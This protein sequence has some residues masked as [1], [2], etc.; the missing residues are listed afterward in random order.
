MLS[1]KVWLENIVDPLKEI[2]SAEFQEEG[3]VRGEIYDSCSFADTISRLFDDGCLDD[4]VNKHAKELGFSDEQI[5]KLDEIYT[6]LSHYTDKNGCYKDPLLIINDPEWLKIR[7]IAQD[8][9]R[10]L[11][12]EKYLDPSKQVLRDSLLY[13]VDNIAN[14][15]LQM[16]F[17]FQD[18][19]AEKNLITDLVE[20]FFGVAKA[21][22]IIANHKDYELTEDQCRAL[23]PFYQALLTYK[24]MKYKPGDLERI[25][26][27]HEWQQTQNLARKVLRT[28]N[29]KRE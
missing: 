25:V 7:V 21:A 13:A 4:F 9:L 14:L 28:F 5:Q 12:V 24:N 18:A 11:H 3:W 17:R 22:Q 23:E 10:A 15:D 29:F 19:D 1:K 2:A 6:A 20:N 16:L 8:A 26:S 27:S